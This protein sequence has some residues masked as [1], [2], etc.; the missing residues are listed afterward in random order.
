VSKPNLEGESAA[1]HVTI[2]EV[3]DGDIKFDLGISGAY[4][5]YSYVYCLGIARLLQTHPELM[6]NALDDV[7]K[8]QQMENALLETNGSAYLN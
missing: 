4:G 7:A 5:S 2:K 3:A 1:L 6:K 8:A